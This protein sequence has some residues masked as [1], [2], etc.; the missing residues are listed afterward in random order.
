MITASGGNVGIQS[1]A[2]VVQSLAN[3]NVFADSMVKR[4]LKV[5]LV[6]I[7]TGVIL[8]LMVFGSVILFMREESRLKVSKRSILFTLWMIRTI[9]WVRL[10]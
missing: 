3:P 10:Q 6:A 2:I 9:L 5:F 1:S 8:S 7:V 4:L